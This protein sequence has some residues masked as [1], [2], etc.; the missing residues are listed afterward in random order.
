MTV[1]YLLLC[2][3]AVVLATFQNLLGVWRFPDV[4]LSAGRVILLVLDWEN[5]FRQTFPAAL[6]N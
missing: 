3:L 6:N 5:Y 2:R 4:D 1:I